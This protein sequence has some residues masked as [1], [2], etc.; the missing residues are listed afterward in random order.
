MSEEQE[1][2]YLKAAALNPSH[3]NKAF[4]ALGWMHVEC[5]HRVR[6]GE[7]LGEVHIPEMIGRAYREL[8][9]NKPLDF[10]PMPPNTDYARKMALVAGKYLESHGELPDQITVSVQTADRMMVAL[11]RSE[12]FK[13]LQ[14][15]LE[16]SRKQCEAL[17]AQSGRTTQRLYEEQETR[18]RLEDELAFERSE[19]KAFVQELEAL[20][21]KIVDL[22]RAINDKPTRQCS[23]E[24]V[25][26]QQEG[27]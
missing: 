18:R 24:K 16:E 7:D 17:A 23:R 19:R 3:L 8:G 2:E 13:P 20:E 4:E 11:D 6:N 9:L 10:I 25:D 1:P 12:G 15:K 21:Q 22:A 26:E 5:I 14:V 27:V